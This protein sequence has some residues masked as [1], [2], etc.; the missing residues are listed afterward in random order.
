MAIVDIAGT[1]NLLSDPEY[2]S[3]PYVSR[4]DLLAG[5]RYW[6]L[7]GG[8]TITGPLGNTA[9]DSGEKEWVDPI[10]GG[11]IITPLNFPL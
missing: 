7:D 2:F 5:I 6:L 8:L 4:F 1:Y 9:S 11:R 10:I 3:V